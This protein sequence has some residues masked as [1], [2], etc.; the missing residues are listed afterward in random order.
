MLEGYRL[1]PR[2]LLGATVLQIMPALKE[3]PQTRTALTTAQTLVQ[4]GARAIIAAENGSLLN[5]MQATGAEWLPLVSDSLNPIK[6]HRSVRT[7]EQFIPAERVD[8]VHAFGPGAAWAAR[9]AAAKFP[10]RIVTSLPD[11]PAPNSAVAHFLERTLAGGDRVI[12][13]S[14]F[15]A[16]PWIERY[17]ISGDRIAIVPHA[18]D[19]AVL[20]PAAVSKKRI[21]AIREAWALTPADRAILVPGELN[22]ANGQQLLIE[23]ARTLANGGARNLVFVLAGSRAGAKR[24]L[25]DFS[26]RARSRG[27]DGLF[28]LTP[29]PR[30]WPAALAAAHTIAVPALQPP[31]PGRIVAQAQA[32]ARPVVVSDIGVLPEQLLAPPRMSDALR[33]GWLARPGDVA[34]FGRALHLALTLDRMHYQ[35]MAARGRQFAEFMFSPERVAAATHAVYTG[36]LARER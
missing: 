20:A 21:Q 31:G 2:T 26:A 19:T 3:Q 16:A 9:M 13:A 24:R 15:V 25:D 5:A 14:A 7:L 6:L 17:R 18:V 12:A 11:G 4:A 1:R 35:A 30:D 34:S 33:T 8:I 27:V 10:I 36:L 29:M 32:M 23:V 22:P 28:R